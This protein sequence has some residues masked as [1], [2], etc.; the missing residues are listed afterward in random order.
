MRNSTWTQKYFTVENS[1]ADL[2]DRCKDKMFLDLL[3]LQSD[4]P[5]ETKRDVAFRGLKGRISKVVA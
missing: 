3:Q 5:A 4:C 1:L 2:R